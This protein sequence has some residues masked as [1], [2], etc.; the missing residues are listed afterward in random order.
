MNAVAAMLLLLLTG[1]AFVLG[2]AFLYAGGTVKKLA[3]DRDR[4]WREMQA[5]L[6]E[7]HTLAPELSSIA[8]VYI[9]WKDPIINDV[10]QARKNAMTA[11]TVGER[12][13]AEANLSWAIARL[14]L[15]IQDIPEL[16]HHADAAGVMEKIR[17]VEAR[18]ARQRVAY[19]HKEELLDQSM[20]QYW[21]KL[22]GRL[23]NVS[24]MDTFDLDPELAREA[25]INAVHC[26]L[27]RTAP[28]VPR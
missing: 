12:S 21:A 8:S 11:H 16:L 13:L 10:V 18:L 14:V 17:S 5:L 2:M 24:A 26:G 15:A 22:G 27:S 28:P 25:M 4:C 19:N 23:R 7:R 3:E 9:A 6:K 20:E 1:A